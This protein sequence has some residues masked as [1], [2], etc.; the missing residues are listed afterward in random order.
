MPARR[1]PP[2]WTVEDIS[3]CFVARDQWLVPS[4]FAGCSSKTGPLLPLDGRCLAPTVVG[5][6]PPTFV[7]PLLP[8]G[9]GFTPLPDVGFVAMGVGLVG[10]PPTGAR[11]FEQLPF[12][13]EAHDSVAQSPT[14]LSPD[15]LEHSIFWPVTTQPPLGTEALIVVP[16]AH[17]ILPPACASARSMC[18]NHHERIVRTKTHVF[19][20][21][22]C[23]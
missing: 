6:T 9:G 23:S 7:V 10:L 1:F 3:A 8:G 20:L 16:F 11:T 19:K 17:L 14:A 4:P 12:P 22:A 2:P 21:M 15:L 13:S 18:A 5:G